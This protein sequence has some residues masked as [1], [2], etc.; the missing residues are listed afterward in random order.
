[1]AESSWSDR[2]QL[3][4]F[5]STIKRARRRLP[6]PSVPHCYSALSST[7]VPHVLR[8]YLQLRH[9]GPGWNSGGRTMRLEKRVRALEARLIGAPVI[10]HFADGSKRELRGSGDFL[11]HLFY[12][13]CGGAN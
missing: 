5:L 11:L 13:A 12:G 2:K 4:C 8:F 6:A 1:M 10:L 3:S 7:N 9:L